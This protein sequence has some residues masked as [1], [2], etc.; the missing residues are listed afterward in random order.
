MPEVDMRVR[1]GVLL[2]ALLAGFSPAASA[3]SFEEATAELDGAWRGDDFFLRVDAER[4]QASVDPER[5]F[6]WQ[7]FLV[8]EVAGWKVT[9]MIGSELFQAII[10]PD[11]LLV[12]STSFRGS[13]LLRRAA[14]SAA[15]P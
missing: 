11:G 4:A 5:P 6:Q 15:G 1:D 8:K 12:T 13:R 2:L 14:D 10:G 3:I 9:F 7:R